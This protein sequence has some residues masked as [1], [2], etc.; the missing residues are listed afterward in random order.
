[1]IILGPPLP[2]PYLQAQLR[3]ESGSSLSRGADH[4]GNSVAFFFLCGFTRQL[5]LRCYVPVSDGRLRGSV[6]APSAQSLAAFKAALCMIFVS[7][8]VLVAIVQ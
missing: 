5:Q 1:M 7:A 6:G 3:V 2:L 4:Q 8:P